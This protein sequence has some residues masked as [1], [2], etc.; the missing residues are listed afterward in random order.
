MNNAKSNTKILYSVILIFI[1][2][3]SFLTSPTVNAAKSPVINKTNCSIYINS[4]TTLK[5]SNAGKNVKWSSKNSKIAKIAKKYGTKNCKVTIK[6]LKKGSTTIVAKIG[7]KTLKCKVTVKS[8]STGKTVYI[9]A[10][11]KKYHRTK[12]CSTLSRSKTIY[13]LSL[14]EAKSEGY[15]PCKVCY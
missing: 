10:T 7:N 5:I 15:E 3:V 13:S 6:G 12:Y 1:M 14:S 2:A 9:T 4:K 11:G 8:K